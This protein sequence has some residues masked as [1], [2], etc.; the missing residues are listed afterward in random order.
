MRTSR[1]RR[2]LASLTMPAGPRRCEP[3]GRRSLADGFSHRDPDVA[4]GDVPARRTA[5]QQTRRRT[6]N[7]RARWGSRF[8]RAP[9][10]V[11]FEESTNHVG[12]EQR[13]VHALWRLRHRVQRGGEE[14][15]ADELPAGC[16]ESWRADL[17]AN[18][19]C[20]MWLRQG[21]TWA[22]HFRR[23][24]ADARTST[25]R[26]CRSAQMSWCWPPEHWGRLRSCC[27]RV[28]RGLSLSSRSAH[29]SAAMVTCWGLAITPLTA[30]TAS[31]RDQVIRRASRRSVPASR[32]SSTCGMPM[33]SK[34]D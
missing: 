33:T 28:L 19:R 30:S 22:V 15:H 5:S 12:V 13:R 10:N 18:A 23:R 14:H 31:A 29:G 20:G 21:D 24:M 9:I 16:L 17:R 1:S 8:R 32:A 34:T 4:T 27:A 2:T 3:I 6:R 11:T 25:T 7:P 26:C